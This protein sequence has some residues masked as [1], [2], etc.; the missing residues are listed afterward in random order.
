MSEVISIKNFSKSYGSFKA[1]KNLNLQ[2]NG[3]EV[4]GFV[5]KNGAG[6]STTIRS[7]INLIHPTEGTIEVLG[8]DSVK[9]S[10]AINAKVS[11]VPS[12]S[13]FYDNVTSMELFKFCLKFT[14]SD[15]DRV[16]ELAEYFELDLNKK[17]SDLSLG[18]RKKVS[19]I[20][21]FLKDSEIII[22]DE[23][24]SGLDPLMQNKFF[25]LILKEKSKGKT[26]FLSSHNLSEVEK[27]CDRVAII[28]DGELVDLFNMKDVKINHKQIVSYTTKDGQNFS[29]DL[30][31]DINALIKKLSNLDLESLEIKSKTVEDEFIEYYKEDAKNE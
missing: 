20:Q 1:V 11:Y 7:I 3:G 13:V 21:A 12:E 22:L 4:F 6:K 31:E 5:G 15:M 14:N 28:K 8:M 18:N 27:Y 24:T 25:S 29:Y 10:K 2:I 19:L 26:I 23:P 9:M 16:N 30:E 17:V